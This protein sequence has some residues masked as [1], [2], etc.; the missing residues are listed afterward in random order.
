ML[1][2]REA[3]WAANSRRF[4][5]RRQTE[6]IDDQLNDLL[7]GDRKGIRMINHATT[8]TTL[9]KRFN[10]NL[11]LLAPLRKESGLFR[12]SRPGFDPGFR[13]EGCALA[14]TAGSSLR[15]RVSGTFTTNDNAPVASSRASFC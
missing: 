11:K 5:S 7:P 13:L 15:R 6:T 9:S 8:L 10:R 2:E 14:G 4:I 12:F 3:Q 1:N